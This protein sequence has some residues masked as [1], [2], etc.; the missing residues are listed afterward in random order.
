MSFAGRVP[1]NSTSHR[2]CCLRLRSSALKLAHH[3]PPSVHPVQTRLHHKLSSAYYFPKIAAEI[4]TVVLECTPC[5][6]NRLRLVKKMRPMKSFTATK[7]LESVAID[8]LGLLPTS[9]RGFRFV[10]VI[11]DRFTNLTKAVPLSLITP[12]DVTVAFVDNWFFKYGQ[13]RTLLFNNGSQFVSHFFQRV[14]KLT[15]PTRL[16]RRTTRRKMGK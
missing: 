1:E 12:F 14:R 8:I 16:Q 7:P 2:S 5:A 4:T 11:S 15:S 6:K 3:N 9:T 13:P 10:L